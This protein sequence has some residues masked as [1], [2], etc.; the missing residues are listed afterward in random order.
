M[1]NSSNNQKDRQNYILDIC[2]TK[3][4]CCVHFASRNLSSIRLSTILCAMQAHL[5]HQGTNNILKCLVSAAKGAAVKTR[6]DDRLS[7]SAESTKHHIED[8]RPERCISSTIYSGDTPFWSEILDILTEVMILTA[9][10]PRW[11]L[12]PNTLFLIVLAVCVLFI[13]LFPSISSALQP[14]LWRS[15][16]MSMWNKILIKLLWLTKAAQRAY[17]I[18]L[19]HPCCFNEKSVHVKPQRVT[20]EAFLWEIAGFPVNT[21][22]QFRQQQCSPLK[23]FLC[24]IQADSFGRTVCPQR[25]YM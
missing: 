11:L 13:T 6:S 5:T 8:S 25:T 9:D 14:I 21:Q 1:H 19:Q 7:F 23:S 20:L 16:T 18:R 17:L 2:N 3:Q 4:Q 15:E 22:L 12:K 10:G 24:F